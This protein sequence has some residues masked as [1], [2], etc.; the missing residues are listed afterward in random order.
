ML[1]IMKIGCIADLDGSA[2]ITADFSALT[3]EELPFLSP[4]AFAVPDEPA[5][6]ADGQTMTGRELAVLSEELVKKKHIYTGK[7]L[8]VY[9]NAFGYGILELTASF[10]F[11]NT[12]ILFPEEKLTP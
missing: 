9:G 1:G 11:G 3:D 4:G 8:T 12:T 2:E 7:S 6:I 5:L 10:V